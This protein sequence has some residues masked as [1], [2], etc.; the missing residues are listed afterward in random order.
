MLR[1]QAADRQ[2]WKV[3]S[4]PLLLN[5]L[6]TLRLHITDTGNPLWFL[7]KIAIYDYISTTD[8]DLMRRLHALRLPIVNKIHHTQLP[9]RQVHTLLLQSV[10]L[11]LL[12]WDVH[13]SS[14]LREVHQTPSDAYPEF[15]RTMQPRPISHVPPPESEPDA[16]PDSVR[17]IHPPRRP[18]CH[19]S[20]TV[21]TKP[22]MVKDLISNHIFASSNLSNLIIHT[23]SHLYV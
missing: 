7:S 10:R 5:K 18:R 19:V 8:W 13:P 21:A 23:S 2:K 20:S 14:M 16:S 6:R 17:K 11:L 15:V 12:C 9:S 3:H 22:S 1:L 4:N